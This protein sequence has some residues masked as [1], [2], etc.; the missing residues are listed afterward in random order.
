VHFYHFRNRYFRYIRRHHLYHHSPKGS[1]VGYGLTSGFWD[2]IWG[3]RIPEADR[4]ALY[5]YRRAALR[6][7]RPPVI[8]IEQGGAAAHPLEPPLATRD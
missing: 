3:T 2:V 8:F 7:V 5:A 4:R 1:E 6:H